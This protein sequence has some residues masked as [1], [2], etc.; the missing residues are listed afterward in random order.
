MK[1]IKLFSLVFVGLVATSSVPAYGMNQ[2]VPVVQAQVGAQQPT[3]IQQQAFTK[4][5]QEKAALS[6]QL[7]Q[8]ALQ[9]KLEKKLRKK[10]EPGNLSAVWNFASFCM[11]N[12]YRA[13][14]IVTILGI[15][16]YQNAL[17]YCDET[18]IRTFQQLTNI[19]LP[20]YEGGIRGKGWFHAIAPFNQTVPYI[21]YPHE[22]EKICTIVRGIKN[23]F[24][25]S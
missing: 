15:W 5:N 16:Y 20:V 10:L 19:T 3:S 22:N 21:V 12:G 11:R 24:F 9:L 6:L 8:T 4:L 13:A 17:S 2:A 1:K 7:A 23:C 25:G 14:L 18:K